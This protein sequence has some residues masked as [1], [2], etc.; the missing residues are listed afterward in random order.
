MTATTAVRK[1]DFLLSVAVL[2][3]CSPTAQEWNY[4]LFVE[5]MEYAYGSIVFQAELICT[6]LGN[7]GCHDFE[8]QLVLS[9]CC[10]CCC[11]KDAVLS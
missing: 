11:F 4:V 6:Q 1:N 8:L 9:F 10:C 7:P 2:A 5:Q 3:V